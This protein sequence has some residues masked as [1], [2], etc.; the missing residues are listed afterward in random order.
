MLPRVAAFSRAFGLLGVVALRPCRHRADADLDRGAPLGAGGFNGIGGELVLP[1][2]VRSVLVLSLRAATA[3]TTEFPVDGYVSTSCR[4]PESWESGVCAEMRLAAALLGAAAATPACEVT[5]SQGVVRGVHAGEGC[6]YWGIPY[7]APPVGSLRFL[8]PVD[9]TTTYGQ[10][11]DATAVPNA[12]PQTGPGGS[13][14]DEDCLFLNVHAPP[15][16]TAAP[17]LVFVHG[18]GYA[19]GSGAERNG[20]ALARNEDVVVVTLNYRLGALGLLALDEDAPD[21]GAGG[22]LYLDQRS[23]LRWVQRHISAFGGDPANVMLFGQSAGA[24]S[25]CAHLSLPD[26]GL[27]A[28]ALLESVYSRRADLPK[29]GRGD[30]AAATWTFRGDNTA[31]LR[32]RC[33]A[34]TSREDAVAWGEQFAAALNCSDAACLRAASVEAI[35]GVDLGPPPHPVVDGVRLTEAPM[36]A[37][38]KTGGA[39]VPAVLGSNTNEGTFFV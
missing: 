31:R 34:A 15:N 24:S 8:P 10:P 18:G 11:L 13:T 29:A 22:A 6:E 38:A 28:A 25:V 2:D 12:C 5:S 21:G 30:A 14:Y 27:F 39:R 33:D 7:A 1:E 3:S 17:V 37:L 4:W 35:L 16:A 36:A 32:Y 19:M 23:A 9:N 26:E 20:S